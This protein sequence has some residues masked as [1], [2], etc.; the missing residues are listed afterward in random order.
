MT[1]LVDFVN[2]SLTALKANCLPGNPA[3]KGKINQEDDYALIEFR[4][5]EEANNAMA[6]NGINCFGY[7]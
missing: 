5:M 6:L 2:A 4:T 1:V 7:R 3:V